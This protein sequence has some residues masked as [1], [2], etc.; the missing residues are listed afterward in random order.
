[1]IGRHN[2]RLKTATGISA[3]TSVQTSEIEIEIAN[4]PRGSHKKNG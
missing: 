1:M 2:T 3:D 4:V